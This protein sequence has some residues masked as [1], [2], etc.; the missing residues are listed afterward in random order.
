[1][2]KKTKASKGQKG[3]K[4]KS[5][6]KSTKARIPAAPTSDSTLSVTDGAMK[7]VFRSA[8]LKRDQ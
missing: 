8:F 1:M 6:R 2:A 3:S 5:K 4:A 7:D